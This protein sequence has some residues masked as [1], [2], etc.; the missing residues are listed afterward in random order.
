MVF[1]FMAVDNYIQLNDHEKIVLVV[2]RYPLTYAGVLIG[3][4]L[5]LL[6]PFFLLIPLLKLGL[7]GKIIIGTSLAFGVFYASRLWFVRQRD[8]LIITSH[9]VIDI[10]QQGFTQRTISEAAYERI[11]DVSHVVRGA[12]RILFN[13]GTIRVTC[14]DG[15]VVLTMDQVKDPKAVHHTISEIMGRSLRGMMPRHGAVDL[16]QEL[17]KMSEVE[18]QRVAQQ[19]IDRLGAVGAARREEPVSKPRKLRARE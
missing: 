4:G 8:C 12:M 9:R 1:T 5:L 18:L 15:S 6:G 13:Y 3:I 17:E 7:F 11:S 10:H 14:G 16:E 2:R 19:I